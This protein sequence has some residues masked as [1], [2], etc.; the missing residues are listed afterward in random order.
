[1]IAHEAPSDP[2]NH[3]LGGRLITVPVSLTVSWRWSLTPLPR[4]RQAPVYS[5]CIV[6]S[7]LQQPGCRTMSVDGDAL[8]L[9]MSVCIYSIDVMYM[10]TDLFRA[11][12]VHV[13]LT[14]SGGSHY[15]T[16]PSRQ[17][18]QK[19]CQLCYTAPDC[20]D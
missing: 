12:M 9:T 4:S 13:S 15:L 3:G 7:N 20:P 19:H 6:T 17:A 11:L 14:V 10:Y 5:I 18:P 16:T 2:S 1:M 8:T